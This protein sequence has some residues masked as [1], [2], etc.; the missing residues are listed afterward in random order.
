MIKKS[1]TIEFTEYSSTDELSEGLRGLIKKSE[2][3]LSNAYAPYSK[4]RV[5][6]L[7]VLEDGTEVIGT[8]QENAAYPSG[9]CAERVAVFAA[10]AQFP[11]KKID[12]IVLTTSGESENPLTPCGAC[13]Q[14]LIEYEHLQNEGIEVILKSGDSKIWVFS[15]INDLLPYSFDSSV[16][17]KQ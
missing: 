10:K 17:K 5:A 6:A 11:D 9:L 4:F 13:R 7:C 15:S 2:S 8:N 14:V 3:Y 1:F 16:L 12:K